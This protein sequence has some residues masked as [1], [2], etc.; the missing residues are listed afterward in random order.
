MRPPQ[1]PLPNDGH[2]E[3]EAG[4]LRAQAKEA[5]AGPQ[6]EFVSPLL[7]SFQG[8]SLS[9]CIQEPNYPTSK[10]GSDALVFPFLSKSHRDLGRKHFLEDVWDW[11]SKEGTTKG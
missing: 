8:W 7:R 5:P 11:P 6:K 9:M 10:S 4:W 3:G 1:P 2:S